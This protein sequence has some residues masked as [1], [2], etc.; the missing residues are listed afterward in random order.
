MARGLFVKS[1]HRGNVGWCQR[2]A[3][4]AWTRGVLYFFGALVLSIALVQV[5]LWAA[6]EKTNVRAKWLMH[7]TVIH[8][9]YCRPDGV[10]QNRT[11]IS[12]I[13][14]STYKCSFSRRVKR[15]TQR[16]RRNSAGGRLRCDTSRKNRGSQTLHDIG[17]CGVV[18]VS[19]FLLIYHYRVGMSRSTA[20]MDTAGL[21][22]AADFAHDPGI[23][24]VPLILITLRRAFTG[25]F[26]KH[27]KIARWTL[28]LWFYVCVTGVIV[29][30]GVHSFTRRLTQ[31]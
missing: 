11:V 8:I 22:R 7:A 19:N 5:C 3:C 10:R 21:F 25:R 14:S 9:R 18:R 2:I 31:T 27:R 4:G 23:V 17:V 15:H 20:G 6:A 30:D 13:V 28:P 29:L 16:T 26:D 24:I 12:G 1:R